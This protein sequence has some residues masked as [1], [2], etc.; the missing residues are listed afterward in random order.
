MKNKKLYAWSC[1]FNS[2]TGEGLLCQNFCKTFTYEKKV[3][4]KLLSPNISA[5]IYKSNIKIKKKII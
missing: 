2:N 5:E 1:D 3:F 4:I